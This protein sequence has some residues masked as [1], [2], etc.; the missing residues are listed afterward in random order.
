MGIGSLDL[1]KGFLGK[2]KKKKRGESLRGKG[3]AALKY[4]FGS[5][6]EEEDL[7]TKARVSC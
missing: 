4:F 3:G 1:F 6:F 7:R 5:L 2:K